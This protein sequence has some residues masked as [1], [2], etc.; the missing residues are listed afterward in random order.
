LLTATFRGFLADEKALK[1]LFDYKGASGKKFC[2]SCRNVVLTPIADD[3]GTDFVHYKTAKM[4]E[5]VPM[6]DD[7]IYAIVDML[8]A[9]QSSG[10]SATALNNLETNTGVSY[11]E[12]GILFDPYLRSI[13][14]PCQQYLRD[15]M[16]TVCSKGVASTEL[17]CIV[18]RLGEVN[19]NWTMATLQQY[20]SVWKLPKRLGSVRPGWFD[21]IKLGPDHMRLFVGG[22]SCLACV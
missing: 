15:T 11:N 8:T 20:C 2:M 14:K 3:G 16:H 6:T 4:S 22:K 13:I 7:M 9:Q 10:A 12:Y 19:T 17:C 5:C 18:H 21:D 1:E